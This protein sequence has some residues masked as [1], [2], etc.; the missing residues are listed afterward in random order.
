MLATPTGYRELTASV[1]QH[2]R[3][4]RA[5][6]P[7][8]MKAFGDLTKA[9]T[10]DGALDKKTKELIALSL[11]IAARCD[12]CIGFHWPWLCI[13]EVGHQRCTQLM[14]LP[15]ST[16]S[17]PRR[18]LHFRTHTTPS[19]QPSYASKSEVDFFCINTI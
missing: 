16:N 6:T 5:D 9:A 1:A 18:K 15:R 17:Q 13:W 3:T 4:L 11:G 19:R 14:R 2:L 8:V 10:R 12:A 7:E